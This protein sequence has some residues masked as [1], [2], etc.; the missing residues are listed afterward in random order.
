MR[1]CRLLL[2]TLPHAKFLAARPGLLS[3]HCSHFRHIHP[4]HLMFAVLRTVIGHWPR[5][6]R[7]RPRPP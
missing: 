1:R 6:E 3:K 4:L 5:V 7:C 2:V